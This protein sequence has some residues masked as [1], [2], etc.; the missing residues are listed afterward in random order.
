MLNVYRKIVLEINH[1]GD[2][3]SLRRKVQVIVTWPL[4]FPEV[5]PLGGLAI[6]RRTLDAKVFKMSLSVIDSR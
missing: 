4:V 6:Y 3:T 5:V 2:H 1:A